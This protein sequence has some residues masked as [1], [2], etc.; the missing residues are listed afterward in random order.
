VDRLTMA[1]SL[2]ARVPFL[3]LDMIELAQRIPSGLKLR[4]RT[5]GD[6]APVEKWILRRAFETALPDEIVWRDKKQFDEGTGVSTL[7]QGAV[8]SILP[9][10]QALTHIFRNPDVLLRSKEEVYYHMV[11]RSLFSHAPEITRSMGRWG[12]R[13]AYN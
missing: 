1:H 7:M 2:E 6:R 5:P 11:F 10:A 13:P 3:D 4:S 12:V 8:D 9:D